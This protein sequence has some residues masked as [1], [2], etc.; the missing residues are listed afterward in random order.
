MIDVGGIF[1]AECFFCVDKKIGCFS[2]KDRVLFRKRVAPVR[3]SFFK[4]C[5]GAN[6]LSYPSII[7]N[8]A[9]GLITV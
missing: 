8:F 3:Y 4:W 7:L 1:D 9:P 2:I 5:K 6:Y